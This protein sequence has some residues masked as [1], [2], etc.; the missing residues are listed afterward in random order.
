MNALPTPAPNLSATAAT[1]SQSRYARPIWALLLLAP[2]IGEVLS[3]STRTSI[4]FVFIPEVMVWGVGALFCRELARR[5]R[6][7][8]VSLLL[9]GM[10]LS[11]AEE[12]LIQQTSLAPL[13]F[14]GS[15]ADY[16]RIW[17]VNLVYL[18]FMLGYESVWV[19]LVP[20]QV[21]E[22]FFPRQASE[23]W[24]RRR[25][26]IVAC[27][28][29]LLGCRIAWYGWT[30]QARP[31]M[32]A[33][34]YHPP[35]ALL[36]L[37]VV[38]ILALI[39]LAYLMRDVGKP[40]T[41][42]LRKTAPAWLAGLTA[43]VMGS[44]WFYLVAQ[45]FVPK[46]VQPFWIAI[47]AGCVWSAL[48]FAIFVRWSSRSA[49]KDAQRF[50]TSFGATLAGMATPYLTIAYWPKIDVIGKIIFDIVALVGFG[51][52]GWKVFA[53]LAAPG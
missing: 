33:A 26:T 34:P 1:S 51:V 6:A 28:A 40:S 39:A 8:G 44:A 22:L 23:P 11:V 35:L 10:A 31:R 3:G 52:L 41:Q 17:G 45:N 18:L 25:G 50:A 42:D 47:L 27:I 7:G 36:A 32:Q 38:G 46:P 15:H 16:G 14:P 2:F 21:T 12:F 24:L 5:W 9:L 19:V 4:L 37:G 29:F 20:V 53:R 49:W 48:A 30:Q 13:P 43:F